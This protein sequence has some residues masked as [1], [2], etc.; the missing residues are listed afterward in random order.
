MYGVQKIARVALGIALLAAAAGTAHADGALDT[1]FGALG[2]YTG[3]VPG[4]SSTNTAGIVVQGDGRILLGT[5]ASSGA[6]VCGGGF[7]LTRLLRNAAGLDVSFGNSGVQN[8]CFTALMPAGY[9]DGGYMLAMAPV[10]NG[11]ALLAGQVSLCVQGGGCGK[12]DV[13]LLRVDAAG[14]PDPAF[15][16]GGAMVIGSGATYGDAYYRAATAVTVAP[17]GTVFAAG[18]AAPNIYTAN[19]A[20]WA[21]GANGSLIREFIEFGPDN[22]RASAIALQPDGKIVVAGWIEKNNNTTTPASVDRDCLISR[23][24]LQGT[25][26]SRDPSF[27]VDGRVRFAFDVGGVGIPG[28]SFNHDVC[29][30][31]AV[32]SDGR[33]AFA[34]ASDTDGSGGSRGFAGRLLT[35]GDLDPGF[36]SGNVRTYYFESGATGSLNMPTKVLVQPDG[37]IVIVG[38]GATASGSGRAIDFGALRFLVDGSFD[39]G[40]FIGTT[41]GS[42]GS[43][44]MVDFSALTGG[45]SNDRGYTAALDGGRVVIAGGEGTYRLA[46]LDADVIFGNGFQ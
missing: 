23:Y 3:S 13:A 18:V 34:G 30:S 25:T 41:P 15:N 42:Q 22:A 38:Y 26:L 1:S 17:N 19:T 46:R 32:Q 21:V 10:S 4:N 45:S 2:R 14:V 36:L 6:T 35:N 24:V 11:G 27:G 8:Y 12:T 40:G 43:R 7:A 44:S 9:V 39:Y 28:V 5:T 37:K 29:T 20:L 31:V 16:G 33:I